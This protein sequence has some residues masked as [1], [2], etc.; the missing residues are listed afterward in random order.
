VIFSERKKWMLRFFGMIDH[1]RQEFKSGDELD[2]ILKKSTE[3]EGIKESMM[4]IS[5]VDKMMARI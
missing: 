2:R 4:E 3:F 1:L 5:A